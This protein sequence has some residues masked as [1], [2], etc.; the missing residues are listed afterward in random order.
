M[1][2]LRIPHVSPGL[3]VQVNPP[4][5]IPCLVVAVCSKNMMAGTAAVQK[6]DSL[7]LYLG[8]AATGKDQTRVNA[9][10]QI[11]LPAGLLPALFCQVSAERRKAY[12][13]SVA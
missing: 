4:V 13:V 9:I 2:L 10:S 3:L 1:L 6:V 7:K 11:L 8:C 12:S 5:P